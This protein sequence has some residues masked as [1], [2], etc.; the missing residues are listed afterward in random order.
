MSRGTGYTLFL[1]EKEAVLSLAS[2]D[3]NK[4]TSSVAIRLGFAGSRG[5][6][7]LEAADPQP[8]VSNY[9]AGPDHA[10]WL[11]GLAHYG[12]VNY[13]S[14][15][16]GVDAV[17]Y[18][19]QRQL[20]YDFVVAPNA[21]TRQ[22]RLAFDGVKGLRVNQAGELVLSTEFGDLVQGKPV[23]YQMIDGVRKPVGA[24]YQMRGGE[25]TF[26]LARY[27]RGKTLIIDP[28]LQWS[29]FIGGT[30]L[31]NATDVAVDATNNAYV[32]GYTSSANFPA[33]LRFGSSIGGAFDAF[34]VKFSTDGK[35]VVWATFLSGEANDQATAVAVDGTGVTVVGY[36]DSVAFPVQ[37]SLQTVPGGGG[38]MFV[39]KLNLQGNVMIFSSY[40]GGQSLD[41]ANDVALDSLGGAVVVGTS[42]SSN[43][44]PAGPANGGTD[45]FAFRLKPDGAGYEYKVLIGSQGNEAAFGVAVDSANNTYLAGRTNSVFFQGTPGVFQQTLANLTGTNDAF[46]TKLS[47]TGAKIYQTLLGGAGNDEGVG[48]D[49]DSAGNAYVFGN[50]D[51]TNFPT[52]AGAYRTTVLAFGDTFVTKINTNATARVW[53][54]YLGGTGADNADRI[55]VIRSTGVAFVVG[56]TT[57]ADFPLVGS[58]QSGIAGSSDIFLT[59][60]TANG[61]AL[62]NSTFFGGAGTELS[63]GLAIDAAGNLYIAGTTSSANLPILNAAQSVISG[64]QD[65]FVTKLSNC[66]VS[67]TPI[68]TGTTPGRAYSYLADIGTVSITGAADC[69]WI[70]QASDSWIT[71]SAPTSGAGNGTVTFT[72]Q[73]NPFGARTGSIAIGNQRFTI[74]QTAGPV[75]GGGCVYPLANSVDILDATGVTKT[76]SVSTSTTNCP[77]TVSSSVPWILVGP[78][79]GNT[80]QPINFLATPNYS[81]VPRAGVVT[82]TDVG[83]LAAVRTITVTQFNAP[84]VEVQRFVTLAYFNLLGRYPALDE[85]NGQSALLLA[86][87]TN[88]SLLLTNFMQGEEF[89]QTSRFVAGL[90]RGLLGRDPEFA[91]WQYQRNALRTGQVSQTVLVTNFLNSAEFN[92]RYGVLTNE[93]FVSLLYLQV[94][95]RGG[96]P[97]EITGQANLLNN[98]SS[99]RVAM[100]NQFLNTAEFR[101]N[102][103]NRITAF[104]LYAAILGRNPASAEVDF[105][106]SQLVF[107]PLLN[108]VNEFA[109]SAELIQQT[110]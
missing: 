95:G 23:A 22:I 15:Y 60:F 81:G 1:T 24:K 96:A 105:R 54:T 83:T 45:A 102:N 49:V 46:V 85:I 108:V 51:S 6:A 101:L 29:T 38:D 7:G 75:A 14:V 110:Q 13:K 16:P 66:S 33:S 52:T 92:L 35:S 106:A 97:F 86:S 77:F 50:T 53:S 72:I 28:T 57:S 64:A 63:G 94:L 74:T 4:K 70:A 42:S 9:F 55:R 11:R 21:D 71:L 98:G 8:G 91:G 69:A 79:S 5:A 12:R 68:R 99:N 56:S 73:Q 93:A 58:I 47:P 18:G 61:A 2:I 88:R 26:A 89:N 62:N 90:Y 104:L 84:L 107:T 40:I 37:N 82:V 25:V 80:S 27:D 41:I 78:F 59:E 48:I 87:Q 103:A 39:S 20:E 43:F 65:G 32:V 76:F 109:T 3:A 100:A 34:V 17:F 67:L 19:N 10:K 31:D 30:G 36:T 44:L